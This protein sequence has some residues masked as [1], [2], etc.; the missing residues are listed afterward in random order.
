[1]PQQAWGKKRERQY[2]H[3]KESE[4]KRGR[5]TNK[6]KRIAAATVNETRRMKSETK[7]GRKTTTGTGNPTTGL[8]SRSKQE[9]YNRAKKLNIAGRSKMTKDQLIKAVRKRS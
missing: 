3:V 6:A 8:E 5:G 4:K 9:L 7:S 1:M 2:E